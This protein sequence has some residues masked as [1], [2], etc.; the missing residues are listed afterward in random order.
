MYVIYNLLKIQYGC[1]ICTKIVDQNDSFKNNWDPTLSLV[2]DGTAVKWCCLGV[3]FCRCEDGTNSESGKGARFEVAPSRQLIEFT[4]DA[5]WLEC[6]NRWSGRDSFNGGSQCR[7]GV[8]LPV[9]FFGEWQSVWRTQSLS[10]RFF[11][12]EGWSDEQAPA[13][14]RSTGQG[15]L[16]SMYFRGAE[17]AGL[18]LNGPRSLISIFYLTKRQH[19]Y[20]QYM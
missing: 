5:E 18:E 17:N 14:P 2:T 9:R 8:E 3:L 15:F 20:K 16:L 1:V 6:W 11:D 7:C 12:E 19:Q 4:V 10:V 13:E